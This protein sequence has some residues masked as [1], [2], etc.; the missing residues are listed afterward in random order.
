MAILVPSRG[1]PGNV[2][3]LLDEID[4]TATTEVTVLIGID[5]DD[6][7]GSDYLDRCIEHP[8]VIMHVAPRMR[9]ARWLD[10]LADRALGFG[11]DHIG[12]MGDDHRPRTEGWDSHVSV[13]LEH[14]G[15]GLVYTA[16]GLQNDR[17]PTSCFW[18]RDII[19]SLG[20]FCPPQLHHMF[21]D[22]FW[23]QLAL[24]LGRVKY[25]PTVMI[26]H[27]HPEAGKA[28]FDEVYEDAAAMMTEDGQA[29]MRLIDSEA[30][31]DILGRV[32]AK[33]E[34]VM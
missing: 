32:R 20:F 14:L 8:R 23:L 27:M 10:L 3:E 34:P 16:D 12:F 19:E 33:L 11:Y 4:S 30:Y 13:A 5:E 17:L 22:N 24:D 18:T 25:L 15:S 1:R 31:Q 9:L 28:Q 2:V 7:T 26:E 29:Y 21:L 6:P